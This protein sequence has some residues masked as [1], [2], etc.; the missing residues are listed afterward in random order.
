[1][2]RAPGLPLDQIKHPLPLQTVTKLFKMLL[3]AVSYMHYQGIC[4]RD[5]KPDN[6][7]VADDFESLKI[8]DFNVA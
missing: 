6:I 5:L 4:H 3:E 7:I 2:E 8:I 1:M